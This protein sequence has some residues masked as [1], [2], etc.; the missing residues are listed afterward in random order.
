[1]GKKLEW[2]VEK[3]D[4]EKRSREVEGRKEAGW[5]EEGIE[6]SVKWGDAEEWREDLPP[7]P[8]DTPPTILVPYSM[9]CC[10]WKVPYIFCIN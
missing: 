6:W 4:G 3:W 9:A 10:V 7:L 5:G 2:R 8:G 1:V